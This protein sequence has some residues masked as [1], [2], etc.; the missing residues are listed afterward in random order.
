MPV[1]AD[2]VGRAAAG[3]YCVLAHDAVRLLHQHGITAQRAADGIL[4][5]KLADLPLETTA[6]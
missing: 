1:R 2:Q 6:R 3:R 5:W 4:E